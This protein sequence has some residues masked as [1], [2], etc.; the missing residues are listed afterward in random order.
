MNNK[1]LNTGLEECSI[2]GYPYYVI[3]EFPSNEYVISQVVSSV[4]CAVLTIPVILLNG[5][6]VLTILKSK[7]LGSKICHFPVLI[8]SMADL[9]VGFLT[10]PLFTFLHLSEVYGGVN[11]KLSFALST[12]AF[13]PW[14]LSLASLCALTFERYMGVLHPIAHRIYLRKKTFVMYTVGVILVTF[15]IVPLAGV[16]VIFYYIFCGAYAIIPFFLHT[17][18][19][20]R[21][22]CSTRKRLRHP[23]YSTS[24]STSSDQSEQ[25]PQTGRTAR[26]YSLREVKLTKSCALVVGTFYICCIPGEFLNIYYLEKSLIIYRVV[27]SWYVATLGV[28]TI[29][30]SIIFFWT[31]PILR[32]EAFKVLKSIC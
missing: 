11:C 4:I 8:Q 14:G 16:S 32:K 7:I 25:K 9:T 15:V 10:L 20:A 28:N 19:Y 23:R 1:S 24:N 12:I 21:I 31:R 30:N 17:F 13:I 3:E 22:L 18:C 26:R 2:A 5:I 27:I 6:T 29:L